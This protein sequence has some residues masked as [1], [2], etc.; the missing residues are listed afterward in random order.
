[1]IIKTDPEQ[2]LA[3]ERFLEWATIAGPE[4][5][6]MLFRV[7]GGVMRRTIKGGPEA[8]FQTA[9]SPFAPTYVKV[10]LGTRFTSSIDDIAAVLTTRNLHWW[11]AADAGAEDA[12]SRLRG[13]G[14]GGWGGYV[15]GVWHDT[16]LGSVPGSGGL[17]ESPSWWPEKERGGTAMKPCPLNPSRTQRKQHY[18]R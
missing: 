11:V 17:P 5:D 10:G 7:M 3:A 12:L 9:W 4:A 18:G 14:V 2:K 1:M 8:G 6:Q 13:G 15:P 16:G